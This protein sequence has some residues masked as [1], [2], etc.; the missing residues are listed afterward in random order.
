MVE[1]MNELI[2]AIKKT[3]LAERRGFVT[4]SVVSLIG[5]AFGSSIVLLVMSLAGEEEYL[6]LGMVMALV[7]NVSLV[8]FGRTFSLL[9]D[10][11][12]AI[13]FG[14]ARKYYVPSIYLVMVAE[15]AWWMILMCLIG[16]IEKVLYAALYPGAIDIFGVEFFANHPSVILL[17][18]LL[19]PAIVVLFGAL[20]AKWGMKFFWVCWVLWMVSFTLLPRMVN[21]SVHEP[22]S[23]LGR[24]GAVIAQFI[25]GITEASAAGFA[26]IGAAVCAVLAY[27]VLRKQQVTL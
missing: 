15:C 2:T 3:F 7:F 23:I 22:D 20:F 16:A 27:C 26:I 19:L 12:L 5:G 13:S 14:M 18:V 6:A 11:N 4:Y 1:E 10:F 24:A 8:F 17:L 25:R 21:A 9:H